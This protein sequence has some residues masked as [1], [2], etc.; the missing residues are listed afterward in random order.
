MR[1]TL[2]NLS[3]RRNCKYDDFE[4]EKC[5]ADL[6]EA[7]I[8]TSHVVKATAVAR[9]SRF[10][11]FAS[12]LVSVIGASNV[13]RGNL[14]GKGSSVHKLLS[15]A[16]IGYLNA[17]KQKITGPE[18]LKKVINDSLSKL[19]DLVQVDDGNR[20]KYSRKLKTCSLTCSGYCLEHLIHL[21]SG[22]KTTKIYVSM[23]RMK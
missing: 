6:S 11:S 14:P 21:E 22:P 1:E 12:R 20:R 5:L 18:V 19:E 9:G 15:I 8:R 13:I 2:P 4:L 3:R 23:L 10:C 16:S 17:W 7:Y